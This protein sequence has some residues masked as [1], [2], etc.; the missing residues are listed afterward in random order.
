MIIRLFILLLCLSN[1]A[2]CHSVDLCT[3]VET[4]PRDCVECSYEGDLKNITC[5]KKSILL[6]CNLEQYVS[7]VSFDVSMIDY[8]YCHDEIWI[9]DFNTLNNMSDTNRYVHDV[10]KDTNNSI[11]ISE[12]GLPRYIH[13]CTSC[14]I[15]NKNLYGS[16]NISD[17]LDSH[18]VTAKCHENMY[19]GFQS[20]HIRETFLHQ[21]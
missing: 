9:T 2:E 14:P 12:F 5:I 15:D 13:K 19:S 18:V 7:K 17:C 4:K 8:K 21:Y 1:F 11:L 3:N 6:Q 20:F 10:F 16:T